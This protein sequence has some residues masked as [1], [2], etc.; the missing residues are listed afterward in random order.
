MKVKDL[1]H[2][3][4]EMIPILV[5]KIPEMSRYSGELNDAT[6]ANTQL[7]EAQ[8]EA[9]AKGEVGIKKISGD[10]ISAR[11]R[12]PKLS[13]PNPTLLPNPI[14][15]EQNVTASKV[16]SIIYQTDLQTIEEMKLKGKA[17]ITEETRAKYA[18]PLNEFKFHQTKA[19]KPIN[20]LHEEIEEKR[21]SEL[22]FNNVY[23]NPPPVPNPA[24]LA[25]IDSIQPNAVSIL[26]EDSLFRKQQSKDAQILKN[27]EEEL[28]D[29]I[30]YYCWQE[31]MEKRDELEKLKYVSL[32]RE[33][34]K[35]SSEE[36]KV[37]LEKQKQDNYSVAEMMRRQNELIKRQQQVEME[38]E[39]LEK[40]ARVRDVIQDRSTKPQ[41]AMTKVLE[42]KKQHSLELKEQLERLRL[43]KIEE[44]EKEESAKADRIRQ[45]KALNTVH[46]KHVIVFDPTTT[47][48]LGL[49]DE[50]SYMEMKERLH[51]QRLKEE[52]F[53]ELRNEE[54]NEEKRKRSEKLSSKYES[55]LKNRELKKVSLT[56]IRHRKLTQLAKDKED[57][58]ALLATQSAIW[59]TELTR[60]AQLKK[61][62]RQK[63]KEEQEKIVRQQQYLG[64]AQEQVTLLREKEIE[65]A[66]ERQL[67]QFAKEDE[68]VYFNQLL[69]RKKENQN[70]TM[71]HRKTELEKEIQQ[72]ELEKQVEFEKNQ[73][74]KK[75]KETV[76]YKKAL[77]HEGQKQH[78][79]TRSTLQKTNPYATEIS[80]KKRAEASSRFFT[81]L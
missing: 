44:K 72:N 39:I 69:V 70:K 78:E 75:L 36:A 52:Q 14:K 81:P 48:K 58:D 76:V 16:P 13:K 64:V 67:K 5:K 68:E 46:R 6:E 77:Y 30:E 2:I 63:L 24:D 40:Q 73:L 33:Q 12:S 26:R 43:E 53:V 22:Q 11:P 25:L 71:F 51:Q 57:K 66:K 65:L 47:P 79:S 42:E 9:F 37:A 28:R 18:N 21:L 23:Y 54:I 50:M 31:M 3:E 74:V 49:L 61:H 20:K 59:E 35:Q 8:K 55:I 17:K 19:G 7:E 10:R 1:S 38:I 34:A 32:R 4:N 15:I 41:E 27:Y 60:R 62:E 29:P 56:Q 45:L 80:T